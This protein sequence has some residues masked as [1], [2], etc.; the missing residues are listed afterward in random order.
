MGYPIVKH[1]FFTNK[2]SPDG[3]LAEGSETSKPYSQYYS[4][5]RKKQIYIE[6]MPARLMHRDALVTSPGCTPPCYIL[7]IFIFF[8]HLF[9]LSC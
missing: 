2:K 6:Q 3:I 4:Y 8:N 1:F 9:L 5:R 7:L